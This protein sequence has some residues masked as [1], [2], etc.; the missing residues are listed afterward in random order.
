M[1]T[2][3]ISRPVFSENFLADRI[4]LIVISKHHG[5]LPYI[6][7][8][9]LQKDLR[10]FYQYSWGLLFIQYTSLQHSA[11][12]VLA[13]ILLSNPSLCLLNFTSS[14]CSRGRFL[15]LQLGHC[16]L[17]ADSESKHGIYRHLLFLRGC[18]PVLCVA[19]SLKMLF[20]LFYLGFV[21][22]GSAIPAATVCSQIEAAVQKNVHY[23][24]VCSSLN[25]PMYAR[26][27]STQLIGS[28][29]LS[30]SV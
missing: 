25:D 14:W 3:V 24:H 17:Q 10:G 11:L 16:L 12:S 9:H 30:Q 7:T 22:V 18:N 1:G 29:T 4:L 20:N 13:A 21:Y 26:C 19:Q 23:Q 5:T 27:A 2:Q 28:D 15:V 6:G 8:Q